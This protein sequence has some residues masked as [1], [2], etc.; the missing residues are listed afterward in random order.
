MWLARIKLAA[1]C[2]AVSAP[3]PPLWTIGGRCAV[4]EA[5]Q[6]LQSPDHRLSF[7]EIPSP[8]G[9]PLVGTTL[10]LLAAG[11]YPRLHEYV[12]ARHKELGSVYREAIGPA[13]AVFVSDPQEIQRVFR[14][15]GRAPKHLLPEPW[16]L[17]NE[18]FGCKRGLFFM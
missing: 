1:K 13:D 17:Y 11:S 10:S 16:V 18:L 14:S 4:T 2:P 8:K 6:A 5:A 3:I 7:S 15:E 12:D 9:L